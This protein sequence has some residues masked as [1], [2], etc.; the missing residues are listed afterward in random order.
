MVDASD[1][2]RERMY[3]GRDVYLVNEQRY[4]ERGW[5]RAHTHD[6]RR[7]AMVN[8][9]LLMRDARHHPDQVDLCREHPI[10]DASMSRFA[11]TLRMHITRT[12]GTG[13]SR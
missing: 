11:T 13:G 6:T 10:L 3:E 12:K 8:L 4:T 5:K 7:P 9:Q 1:N 2:E